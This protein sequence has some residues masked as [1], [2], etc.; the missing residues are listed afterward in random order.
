MLSS[1][2]VLLRC[3]LRGAQGAPPLPRLASA[4]RLAALAKAAAGAR[5]DHFALGLELAS[6]A[7]SAR[8]NSARPGARGPTDVLSFA[9]QMGAR[10]GALPERGSPAH[11]AAVAAAAAAAAAATTAT[12]TDFDAADA[13][14]DLGDIVLCPAVLARDASRAGTRLEEHWRAV[15]VHG[16]VHLLGHDHEAGGAGVDLVGGVASAAALMERREREV[17]ARLAELERDEPDGPPQLF[18]ADWR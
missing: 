8:L 13:I 1:S 11:A 5:F 17:A 12:A 6:P 7:A 3:A 18:D 14:E 2:G 10:G 4:L 16:L 9:S 15:L